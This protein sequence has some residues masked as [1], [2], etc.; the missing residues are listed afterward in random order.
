MP[1]SANDAAPQYKHALMTVKQRLTK[2]HRE[3]DRPVVDCEY[4]V[5]VRDGD[6]WIR[7]FNILGYFEDVD[8]AAS[9]GAHRTF[10][11]STNPVIDKVIPEA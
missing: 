9:P 7:V 5:R 4:D 2:H 8:P 3:Q 10:V 6:M 11:V 1:A